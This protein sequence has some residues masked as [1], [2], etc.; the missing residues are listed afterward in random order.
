[1]DN[2]INYTYDANGLMTKE[3]DA[4]TETTYK[5][6]QV[7]KN[8][9]NIGAPYM[10][11]PIQLPTQTTTIDGS[12]TETVNYTYAFDAKKR[13]STETSVTSSGITVIKTYTY[14]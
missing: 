6:D 11:L 12:D 14:Y 1:L 5:Y 7:I 10:P 8:T 2:I 13:L 4:D 3:K 9:V